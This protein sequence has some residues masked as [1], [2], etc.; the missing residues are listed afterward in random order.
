V[1][2]GGQDFPIS[3]TQNR[4]QVLDVAR[5]VSCHYACMTCRLKNVNEDTLTWVQRNSPPWAKI[6]RRYSM[7]PDLQTSGVFSCQKR[8]G[9]AESAGG[10]EIIAALS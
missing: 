4:Y 5:S 9:G 10:A 3:A 6:I 1:G 2:I 8:G 7:K